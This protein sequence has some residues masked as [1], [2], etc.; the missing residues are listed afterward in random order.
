M[1]ISLCTIVK[2][3]ENNL[4]EFLNHH[5]D[6]VDEIIIVDTG[7]VDKTKVIAKTFAKVFDFPWTDDFSVVR[8][9]SISNATK[10]WILWLDAD[11]MINK[12]DFHKIRELTK[13]INPGYSFIQKTFTQNINH[14]RFEEGYYKRRICKLFRKGPKFQYPIH[15]TVAHAIKVKETNI[16]IKHYPVESKEKSQYYLKLLEK[17]KKLFPDS[18]ADKEILTERTFL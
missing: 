13:Q 2:D 10:D 16:V 17:K 18:N 6:L 9:F 12:K 8:N 1:S 3:E 4:E 5:K 7:S 15:E 14:P 11:E